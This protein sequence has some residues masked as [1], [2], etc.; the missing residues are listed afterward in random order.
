MAPSLS[1][2]SRGVSSVV[3]VMLFSLSRTAVLVGLG[4]GG[5]WSGEATL[6]QRQGR[7]RVWSPPPGPGPGCVPGA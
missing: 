6:G 5:A 3:M 7:L 1:C 2:L 4:K